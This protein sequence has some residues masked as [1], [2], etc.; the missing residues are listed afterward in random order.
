[1]AIIKTSNLPTKAIYYNFT[2]IE[3]LPAPTTK[4]AT[5]PASI[6]KPERDDPFN[7]PIPKVDPTPKA[8]F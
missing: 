7:V 4:P 6:P 1:M 8:F 3:V 5:K 2:E